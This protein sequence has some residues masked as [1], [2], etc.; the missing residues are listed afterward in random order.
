MRTF[1]CENMFFCPHQFCDAN[2]KVAHID[3]L[4]FGGTIFRNRKYLR[5]FFLTLV[6]SI[7]Q[8]VTVVLVENWGDL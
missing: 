8:M 7:V 5:T 6:H 1:F 3:F 2:I 4:F